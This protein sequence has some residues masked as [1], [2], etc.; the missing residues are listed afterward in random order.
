MDLPSVGDVAQNL[1]R[2]IDDID[3]GGVQLPKLKDGANIMVQAVNTVAKR[4]G[5]SLPFSGLP[6]VPTPSYPS[7]LP[8]MPKLPV[9]VAPLSI[10]NVLGGS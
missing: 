7:N 2:G 5:L 1:Q 3:L 6:D 8:K 9:Q 4:F 10:P